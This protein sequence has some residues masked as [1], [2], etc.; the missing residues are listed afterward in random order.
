ML[1]SPTL[2]LHASGQYMTK[3]HG[4]CI[5]FSTDRADF[6]QIQPRASAASLRPCWFTTPPRRIRRL[7][8]EGQVTI[9]A[10]PPSG[11]WRSR[12]ST[13]SDPTSDRRLGRLI[14]GWFR[15]A[16]KESRDFQVLFDS[17][18]SAPDSHGHRM[19]RLGR[20]LSCRWRFA[21][22]M[23]FLFAAINN[24][25]VSLLSMSLQLVIIKA[26]RLRVRSG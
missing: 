14:A 24:R 25:A 19:A 15:V 9:S 5:Y 20:M 22:V 12:S 1:G 6:R 18:E 21:I 4:K 13:G 23:Y 8:A 10:S 11:S 3:L 26:E 17:P 7:A 2:R 16:H